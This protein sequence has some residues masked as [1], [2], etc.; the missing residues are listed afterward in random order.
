[1]SVC[2]SLILIFG[3]GLCSSGLF[4]LSNICYLR[5]N[6]RRIFLN[7][8]LINSFLFYYFDDFYYVQYYYTT[9][10]YGKYTGM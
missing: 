5:F 1:M 3:H 10:Y 2:G 4:C 6:S 9:V 8:G 7:K